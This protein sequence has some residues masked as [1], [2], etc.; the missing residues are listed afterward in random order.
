MALLQTS[1]IFLTAASAFLSVSALECGQGGAGHRVV[2]GVEARPN[3]WP[4][5]VFY[6]LLTFYDS[7]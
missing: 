3:N 1:I 7:D 6:N 2:G 5:Q 4:W